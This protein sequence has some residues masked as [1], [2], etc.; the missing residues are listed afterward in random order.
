MN[1]LIET[2]YNKIY[3]FFQK[4]ELNYLNVNEY[5]NFEDFDN[6]DF[7]NAF[8]DI[9]E[10]LDDNNAFTIE[11]IYYSVAMDYLIKHDT[12]LTD[13]IELAL[14]YGFKLEDL[15]S[16]ILASLLATQITRDAFWGLEE[17]INNFFDLQRFT[18]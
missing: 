13:S 4:N 5:L 14:D 12:S 9:F 8:Q 15:N 11:I 10:I 16:E 6:L 3:E 18:I 2:Q 17:D 7:S 1:N